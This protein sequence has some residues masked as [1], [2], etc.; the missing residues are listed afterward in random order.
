MFE[1]NEDCQL[2]LIEGATK[3]SKTLLLKEITLKWSEN[4]LKAKIF[5]G[6]LFCLRDKCVH[7]LIVYC[8]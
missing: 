3:I 4:C 1:K 7:K 5:L 6:L 2:L 8:R